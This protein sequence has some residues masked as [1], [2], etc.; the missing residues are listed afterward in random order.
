MDNMKEVVVEGEVGIEH[1]VA[2]GGEEEIV[3]MP[4]SKE[5]ATIMQTAMID[6]NSQVTR[7]LTITED[8]DQTTATKT[9]KETPSRLDS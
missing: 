8:P 9:N 4:T 7:T 5:V 3:V 1:V 2:A 6:N